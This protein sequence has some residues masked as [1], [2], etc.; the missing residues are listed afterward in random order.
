MIA[1]GYSDA[2]ISPHRDGP[3]ASVTADGPFLLEAFRVDASMRQM[4]PG[5]PWLVAI[6]VAAIEEAQAMVGA[7]VN[8]AVRKR[9]GD[10]ILRKRLGDFRLFALYEYEAPSRKDLA[11]EIAAKDARIAE[12]EG[13]NVEVGVQEVQQPRYEFADLEAAQT[14]AKE[15]Q[16]QDEVEPVVQDA[17][18]NKLAKLA[19][20]ATQATVNHARA[21]KD[22]EQAEAAVKS[23]ERSSGGCGPKEREACILLA[24]S[25]ANWM[26]AAE[27]EAAKFS[28]WA[29]DDY[30]AVVDA[31]AKRAMI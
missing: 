21:T 30:R 8:V 26:H 1:S 23:A 20:L 27:R 6:P 7:E 13:R 11:A 10:R 9:G 24:R 29:V 19:E 18:Q 5:G 3:S 14:A 17:A 25:R 22:A 2:P 28:L 15:A 12:L 16:A 4:E 31:Q